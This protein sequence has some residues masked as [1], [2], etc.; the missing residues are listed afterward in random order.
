MA[1]LPQKS[2]FNSASTA[3]KPA[4][5]KK[6]VD[7]S[8]NRIRQGSLVEYE[9]H[10]KPI[11]AA[12]LAD[13]R[14]KWAIRNET[15][16]ELEL[17]SERLYLLPGTA[18][19]ELISL[20]AQA[21]EVS[22]R[23][24]LHP[25]WEELVKSSREYFIPELT[26]KILGENSQL[27]HLALRRKLLSDSVYFKRTKFGFEPRTAEAVAELRVKAEAEAEKKGGR[28]RLV[29]ALVER[30][31]DPSK[32]TEPLPES[33]YALEQLAAMGGKAEDAKGS[34][35]VLDEVAKATGL[36]TTGKLD[37]RAYELL[38]RAG[39][40]SPDENM[41]IHR[42]RRPIRFSQ[43]V[44]GESEQLKSKY[45][46]LINE[47]TNDFTALRTFTIDNATTRDMDDALSIE[48]TPTGYRVGIHIS[49]VC[50]VIAPGSAL[51]AEGLSRGTSIYCPDSQ[52]PMLPTLLSEGVLSLAANEDRLTMSFLIDVDSSYQITNRQVLI[53]KIRVQQ[54]LNYE[55]VDAI[56]YGEPEAGADSI[57]SD[58]KADLLLL[59]EVTSGQELRRLQ[60]GAVQFSRRELNAQVSD[61]GEI[62]LEETLEDTPGHKLVSELMV[63]ANETAALFAAE[64]NISLVF[65]GQERPEVNPDEYALDV[66][67]GPARDFARRGLLKR[68]VLGSRPLQHYGLGLRAYAQVT[69]PIRRVL[70]LV[71][72]R[73]LSVF[74]T[75]GKPHY[76][77]LQIQQLIELTE[78]PLDEALFIQRDRNRYFLLRYLEQEKITEL[79]GMVMRI[80]GHKP[81]AELDVIFTV[82]PFNAGAKGTGQKGNPADRT[83]LHLGDKIRLRIEELNP[84]KDTL[85]LKRI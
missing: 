16:E 40:F 66:P 20:I 53:S 58:L 9:Q 74:L 57:P 35:T 69:S 12:V 34:T 59:W 32:H 82:A 21:Q 45:L 78:A 44:I 67:E 70:D 11:L 64:K 51:E 52:I 41:T 77:P 13:R 6:G 65:R 33:I 79:D 63:L 61:S 4:P 8:S 24:E 1:L 19:A 38:L 3:G 55:Q 7:E 62:V 30:I 17:A 85:I 28:D 71:N 42:V 50:S 84:K 80:E 2:S 27:N 37:E 25:L 72:Q 5:G 46:N 15:Q 36:N 76:S 47:R 68:S 83:G 56:L 75:T 10:G 48:R 49:D 26:L 81:L 31:K 54:K 43:A 73:Q 14:G 22:D 23:I 39:H 29:R 18:P 60:A